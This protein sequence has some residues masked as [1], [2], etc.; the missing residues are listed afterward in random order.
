M[1]RSET[2][3]KDVTTRTIAGI[4]VVVVTYVGAILLG[5]LQQPEFH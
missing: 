1:L 5:Y 3:W 4:I 2:F